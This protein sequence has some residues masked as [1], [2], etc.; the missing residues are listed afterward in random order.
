MKNIRQLFSAAVLSLV[1]SSVAFAGDMWS[2]GVVN[3]PPPPEGGRVASS[4]Q[5]T[6]ITAFDSLTETA[7][8][9][10]ER[11]LSLF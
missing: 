10:C 6:E 7:V 11:M 3:P 2:G 1:I 9:L 5:N 4:T 8:L